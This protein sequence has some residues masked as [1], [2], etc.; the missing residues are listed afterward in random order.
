MCAWRIAGE[1]CA[2]GP[3]VEDAGETI[4]DWEGGAVCCSCGGADA[5]VGTGAVIWVVLGGI[6]AAGGGG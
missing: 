3:G 2:E 4:V 1:G 6:G 5:A